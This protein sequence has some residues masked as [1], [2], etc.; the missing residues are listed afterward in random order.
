[1]T[2]SIDVNINTASRAAEVL[3]PAIPRKYLGPLSGQ[4]CYLV[5][6]LDAKYKPIRK[7]QRVALGTVTGVEVHPRDVF[8]CAVRCNAVAIIVAHS[9][10]SQHLE[11]SENDIILTT[12]LRECGALL[13]IPVLDHLIITREG[14]CSLAEQGRL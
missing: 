3:R 13:G 14:Y 8:R 12:R 6:C 7:P 9:H 5:L 2:K 10:P 1:M 4:E 11:P